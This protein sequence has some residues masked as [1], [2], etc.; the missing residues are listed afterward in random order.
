MKPDS[1]QLFG[2]E[3]QY[4]RLE[5]RYWR[6][7]L[8]SLKDTGIRCVTTY[9]QWGTHLVGPPDAD[10]P[11]GIL[12]FTGETDPKLNLMGFLA[13]VEELGLDMNF[14][15]GPF[16]CNEMIHGGYPPWLVLGDP[17][18]MVWDYQNRT[19]Q[20]YWIAKKEGSQP[21]YLHPE[22]LRWCA[23][24]I[25]KVDKIIV[26]HLKTNGG[27]ITMLN[28]DNEISYI[29]QDGMLSSDYNPINVSR[30]GFY[31]QFLQ[32]KYGSI[33]QLPY[34]GCYSAIEDVS[35]PRSVPEHIEENIAWYLDWIEFKQWC[36]C[37]YIEALRVM[38]QTNGV[39]E[40]LFMTN[41][42][43]HLP[44]GIP[45]RMPAF[46]QATQ[47]I[48]GYDFYRGTFMSYSGYQSMS[49]VLKL[50]NASVDYT[51]S[52]EFMSG[53]WNKVLESR[54]SDDHMRFM[55][56]CALAHGCKAIGWFMFHDRDCWGDAPVS[57]HG[58]RRT[59]WEVLRETIELCFTK[60]TSWDALVPQTDV[61]VI[62]D[63]IQHRHTSIGD[64][65][66]CNDQDMH[67]GAPQVSGVKAGLATREYMGIFRLAEHAG[68]Q[69]GAVDLIA[70]PEKLDNYSLAFLPGSPII[71]QTASDALQRWVKA[72]GILVVSG[73]WPALSENGTALC[74]LG[75]DKPGS[76]SLGSGRVVWVQE[77]LCANTEPEKDELDSIAFLQLILSQC[78]ILP[79]VHIAAESTISWVDW[80]EGG[81]HGVYLQP[82][83]LGSAVLQQSPTEDILFVLNHYPEAARFTLSF[84]NK[85]YQ[86]IENLDTQYKQPITDGVATVDI[87]RKSASIYRLF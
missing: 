13:L 32:E 61:A 17:N 72:G 64:P 14:R 40:V 75:L 33:A 26:P 50:M 15:C 66:P 71:E 24:W 23:L 80:K 18:I 37:R 55:A 47:G 28:L 7:V 36:M 78:A 12:D 5:P 53:T 59:N 84:K 27:C 82:R 63:L 77:P 62:Y 4:F 86:G 74:F 44:E 35:P 31:H 58:H 8:Q 10:N 81:G 65:T 79:H 87:D 48:V 56:R 16:C 76:Q 21:S 19:T 60:I 51:W 69:A 6:S 83:T 67:V 45:T 39:K 73:P 9:V 1:R 11:A 52:A 68:I 49:R 85:N 70:K 34:A 43:P 46:E 22:Y 30:G 25:A 38:H 54:V 2:S 57:S 20:G 29:V 41:F 42:N 3:I